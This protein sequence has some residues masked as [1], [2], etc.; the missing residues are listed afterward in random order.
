MRR[1]IL[2]L[3]VALAALWPSLTRADAPDFSGFMG[4][5]WHHHP[6]NLT[7]DATGLVTIA[8][9]PSGPWAG[10]SDY[11]QL[12][13]VD[14]TVATGY[15]LATGKPVWL[16]LLPDDRLL[17]EYPLEQIGSVFCGPDA[18]AVDSNPCGA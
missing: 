5:S 10:P 8:S 2:V 1:F 9:P 3:L 6:V 14:G 18:P 12:Q 4:Q 16:I 15:G 13:T 7:V 17:V 11:L